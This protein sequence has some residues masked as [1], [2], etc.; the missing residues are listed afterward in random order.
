MN[1][2][3]D[4]PKHLMVPDNKALHFPRVLKFLVEIIINV[5]IV[6]RRCMDQFLTDA[7]TDQ[8]SIGCI[9]S[10]ESVQLERSCLL[11]ARESIEQ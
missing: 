1:K 11:N 5:E 6:A 2:A 3:S 7:S 10:L 4:T 9:T 8:N